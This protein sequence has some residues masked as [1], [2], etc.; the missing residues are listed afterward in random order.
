MVS[1]VGIKLPYL[2]CTALANSGP[3]TLQSYTKGSS[4]QRVAHYVPLP[5][6]PAI[7]TLKPLLTSLGHVDYEC[8]LSRLIAPDSFCRT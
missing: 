6:P 1:L 4:S 3:A 2:P 7:G 5:T 8:S